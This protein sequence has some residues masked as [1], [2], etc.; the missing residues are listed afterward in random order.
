LGDGRAAQQ[1]VVGRRQPVA[2]VCERVSRAAIH[3]L[4]YEG[5]LVPD[6]FTHHH[7]NWLAAPGQQWVVPVGGGFGRVFKIGD[8]AVN[9]SIQAYYNAINPT[10]APNWQLRA[11]LSLLFPEK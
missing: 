4:Q 2:T 10:G 11:Q 3:Q 6:D 1:S 5:R 8:Q 9:A 7:P